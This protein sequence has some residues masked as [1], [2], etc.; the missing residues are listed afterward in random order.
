MLAL[1]AIGA[2]LPVIPTTIFL[3]LAAWCFGRSFPA[4][5]AWMLAHPRFGPVVSAW[6]AHGAVPRRAKWMASGGMALG[7]V[8]FWLGVQPRPLAAV[9]VAGVMVGGAIYVIS[10]PEP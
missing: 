1:G 8:L 4:L 2:M 10:R 5:E 6:R 9:L 3:I 7:Y